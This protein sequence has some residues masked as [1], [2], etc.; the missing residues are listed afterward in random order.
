MITTERASG[1]VSG[2]QER[3]HHYCNLFQVAAPQRPE[4]REHKDGDVVWIYPIME[5]VIRGIENGDLACVTLGVDFL[6]EDHHFVFGKI[7][8]SNAA[9]SLL[10]ARLTEEQKARLRERIVTMLVFGIIPM[11]CANMRSSFG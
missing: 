8:K 1:P 10:R 9:R 2:V 5:S 6:E 11:K 3:Y 4:A 7:L